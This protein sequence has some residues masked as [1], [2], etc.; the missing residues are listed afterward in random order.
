MRLG[1]AR[2]RGITQFYLSPTH[3][4]TSGMNHP[5]RKLHQMAP[6]E[7]G[8]AHPITSYYSFIDLEWMNV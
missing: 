8:K 7:R 1:M 3:L 5:A 6:P 2:D 4:P